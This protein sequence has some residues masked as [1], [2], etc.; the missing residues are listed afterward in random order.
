MVHA[1]CVLLFATA[2]LPG[3]VNWLSNGDFSDGL[4][5]WTPWTQ[6]DDAGDFSVSVSDGVLQHRGSSY[7]GGVWQVAEVPIGLPL[8]ID[9]HWA[10]EPTV[11]LEAWAEV[12]VI[13]GMHPPADGLDVTSPV[14]YRN[15]TF[16]TAGGWNGPISL[17]SPVVSNPTGG[18][19][20]S[21]SATGR[22]TVILKSGSTGSG[23]LNGV[24]WN[25]MFLIPEPTALVLFAIGAGLIR[26]SRPR[27]R[28]RRRES[29][30]RGGDYFG[31][32]LEIL[33]PTCKNRA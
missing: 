20:G 32:R 13:D 29:G 21:G 12:I 16:F 18:P 19:L 7:N 27:P 14:I 4:N 23:N 24:N 9:G 5:G 15:D 28:F 26:P 8:A 10:S 22:V 11:P 30:L 25:G 33:A 3:H 1:A 6:R 31:R 2:G 17:T